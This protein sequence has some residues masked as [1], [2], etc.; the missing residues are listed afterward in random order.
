MTQAL[1]SFLWGEYIYCGKMHLIE[2]WIGLAHSI[3]RGYTQWKLEP[4]VLL[5]R[6]F[7]EAPGGPEAS[8]GTA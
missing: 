1:S 6:Y 2:Y 5:G 4:R 7:Q 8:H 3:E